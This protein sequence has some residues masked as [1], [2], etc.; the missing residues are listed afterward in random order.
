MSVVLEIIVVINVFFVPLVVF[1]EGS[2]VFLA[3][4]EIDQSASVVKD[5][6]FNTHQL[7]LF[8]PIIVKA[9]EM[10]VNEEKHERVVDFTHGLSIDIPLKSYIK[11]RISRQRI[12]WCIDELGAYY[13]V[14][15]KSEQK[16]DDSNAVL[17]QMKECFIIVPSKDIHKEKA[18][19][20]HISEY[21]YGGKIP[22]FIKQQI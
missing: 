20:V 13:V 11:P 15:E 6:L 14:I 10:S 17:V 18:V 8:D 5:E 22:N 2:T 21:D 19:V 9:E 16:P 7:S 3:S 12:Y 1:N 4:I